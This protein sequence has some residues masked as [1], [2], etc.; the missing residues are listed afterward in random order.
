[1]ALCAEID[2]CWEAVGTKWCFPTNGID[3]PPWRPIMCL[4]NIHRLFCATWKHSSDCVLGIQ[5][6]QH[7][8]G[9]VSIWAA[10]K[11][12]LDSLP[13][14]CARVFFWRR[15]QS[16]SSGPGHWHACKTAYKCVKL[17]PTWGREL[18][19]ITG[20]WTLQKQGLLKYSK[21]LWQHPSEERGEWRHLVAPGAAPR[22]K[23]GDLSPGLLCQMRHPSL[24]PLQTQAICPRHTRSWKATCLPCN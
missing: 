13:A 16:P 4:G 19:R 1:M 22:V 7:C 5:Q 20:Q 10:N 12:Q 15:S 6:H 2:W 17:T 8:M 14:L 9:S 24:G 21:Q 23:C 18:S 11:V 3:F